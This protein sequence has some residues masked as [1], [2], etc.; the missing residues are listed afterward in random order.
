[1]G[2]IMNN[3]LDLV[4][5]YSKKRKILDEDAIEKI[6]NYYIDDFEVS[7][8]NNIYIINKI[9][10]LLSN[11]TLGNYVEDYIE[12]FYSRIKTYIRGAYYITESPIEND[13]ILYERIWRINI[14]ILS[15]LFHE[16][17]HAQQ[18]QISL[19]NNP[20]NFEEKLI[21]IENNFMD[22]LGQKV[23]NKCEYNKET[24]EYSFTIPQMLLYRIAWYLDNKKYDRLYNYSLLERLA[25][26]DSKE[27]II[28]IL[29]EN[30]TDI[31]NLYKLLEQILISRKLREYDESK[32]SPTIDF[33]NKLIGKKNFSY[34]D[35]PTNYTLEERLRL[36]LPISSIEYT[37]TFNKLIL[38]KKENN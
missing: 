16:L 23:L 20:N 28:Y 5:E 4:T 30:K 36:G 15:I 18:A 11:V 3:I 22:H 9:E 27:K 32:D 13:L 24:K 26:I 35:M 21:I 34:D 2:E 10:L 17:E 19:N 6:I 8:I 38:Q 33:F 25:D 14:F 1:M 31:P 7:I 37:E 12:I 29:S